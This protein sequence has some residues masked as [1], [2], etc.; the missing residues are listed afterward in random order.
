MS[1]PAGDPQAALAVAV[2]ELRG[3]VST[4]F[5]ETKGSLS[6]L[7]QRAGQVDE[8]L[9]TQASE[10]DD[11]DRRLDRLER[12]VAADEEVRQADRRRMQL[13]SLVAGLVVAIATVAGTVV[14]VVHS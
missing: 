14:A 3:A 6:L 4:G 2:A 10:I 1:T 8:Q 12:R 11:H 13:L 5:A 9:K 7:V